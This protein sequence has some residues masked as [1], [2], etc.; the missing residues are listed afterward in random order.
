MYSAESDPGGESAQ[1]GGREAEGEG[2]AGF[3][4]S[5]EP[6]SVLS[7]DLEIVTE[8][9]AD[10]YPTEPP[11]APL[12]SYFLIRLCDSDAGWLGP[13][14]QREV[15]TGTAKRVLDFMQVKNQT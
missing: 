3:P 10:A 4:L 6:N 2:E 1:A 7:Q 5:R 8:L 12:I 15:P 9:K 11:Q 14:F 13:R